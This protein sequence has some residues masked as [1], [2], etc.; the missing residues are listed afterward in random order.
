MV[1]PERGRDL[2]FIALKRKFLLIFEECILF[3]F[4]HGF[5]CLNLSEWKVTSKIIMQSAFASF[6]VAEALLLS[7]LNAIIT[8]AFNRSAAALKISWTDRLP[9]GNAL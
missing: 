7:Y 3:I 5:M 4:I 2:D 1:L 9:S 8:E 6:V